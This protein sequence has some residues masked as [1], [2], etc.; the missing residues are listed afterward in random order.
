M[1]VLTYSIKRK[2]VNK[3]ANNLFS[4]SQT[5]QYSFTTSNKY[6]KS[7]FT[8]LWDFGRKENQQVACVFQKA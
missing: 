4:L 6:T 8:L 7:L 3:K 5:S 1:Q 2:Q